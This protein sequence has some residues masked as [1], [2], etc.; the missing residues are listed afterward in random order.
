MPILKLSR[1]T[2]HST[3][4]H[5]YHGRWEFHARFAPEDPPVGQDVEVEDSDTDDPDAV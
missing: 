1:R 2:V 5:F 4:R 3:R